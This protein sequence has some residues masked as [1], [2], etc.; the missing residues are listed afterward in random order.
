M[1]KRI[2][3]AAAKTIADKYKCRQVILLAWDGERTHVVTYGRSVEDCAQAAAGGNKVKQALGWPPDLCNSEPK[4][5]QKL[6]NLVK[7]LEGVVSSIEKGR[8]RPN[9][10]LAFEEEKPCK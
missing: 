9:E 4:R 7:E 8:R 1:P 6:V 2:P 5:V 3:I 10:L